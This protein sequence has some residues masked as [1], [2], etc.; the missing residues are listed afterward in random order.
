MNVSSGPVQYNRTIIKH[1][2][3]T[4]NKTGNSLMPL[5]VSNCVNIDEK[6]DI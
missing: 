2:L 4:L 5:V 6:I 1:S 3:S